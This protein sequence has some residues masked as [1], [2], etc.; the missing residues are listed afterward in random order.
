MHRNKIEGSSH[1][2]SAGYDPVRHV[3][4]VEFKG[5]EVYQYRD[6]P[7]EHYQG[8]MDSDSRGDYHH[9]NLKDYPTVRIR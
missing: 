5:G 9:Q 4:E 2:K 1:I 3:M 8:F 7:L 6:V